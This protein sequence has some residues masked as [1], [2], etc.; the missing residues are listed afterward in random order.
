MKKFEFLDITTADV[1]F[2]AYGKSLDELFEN[3]ALAM[4]DVMI[5]TEQVKP[6][7]ERGVEVRGDD[8]QSLMFN[9]LNELLF[10]CGAE[11]LA[12]S[13]FEVRINEERLDLRARCWGEEMNPGRHELRTEVKA[14]TYH[15]LEVEKADTEWRA[16]VVLDI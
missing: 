11:N 6:R 10:Y 13:R 16:R 4:F 9:W 12:F 15:L 5:N 1:C 14:C 8:L 3:A 2:L 7:V